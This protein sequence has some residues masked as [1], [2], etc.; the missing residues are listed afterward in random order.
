MNPLVFL[1]IFLDTL[2]LQSS[3]TLPNSDSNSNKLKSIIFKH[4]YE[5]LSKNLNKN[6]KFL[7]SGIECDDVSNCAYAIITDKTKVNW[8][9]VLIFLDNSKNERTFGSEIFS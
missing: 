7:V 6:N 3:K 4:D 1:N 9:I 2:S 5:N 8:K